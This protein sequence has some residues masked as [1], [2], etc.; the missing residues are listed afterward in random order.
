MHKV[1]YDTDPGIDDTIA[2]VFQALHPQI[3]LVGITSVFGNS[4]IDTTTA[5]AL[6]LAWRFAPHV[7]VA[8]GAGSLLRRPTPDP[9]P[10][11]HGD[12]ALGNIERIVRVDKQTDAHP[13]HRFIVETVRNDPGQI[14]LL[15]VWPLTNLAR[16]LAD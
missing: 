6:Y 2:F 13:T 9:I 8:R 10:H 1:I 15:A 3:E 14:T 11:I 12:D 4:D 16:A 7:P 5:N